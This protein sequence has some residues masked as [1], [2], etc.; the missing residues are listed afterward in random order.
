MSKPKAIYI[1]SYEADGRHGYGAFRSVQFRCVNTSVPR[2]N[3]DTVTYSVERF[4]G[5]ND[6]IT[7]SLEHTIQTEP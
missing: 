4:D 6:L 1:I 5:S 7:V 3:N 2:I